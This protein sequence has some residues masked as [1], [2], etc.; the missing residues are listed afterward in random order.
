MKLQNIIHNLLSKFKKPNKQEE[1]LN[2]LYDALKSLRLDNGLYVASTGDF[3]KQ[4]VWLRDTFYAALPS[5]KHNPKEYQQ[6]YHTLL[7]YLKMIEEKYNKFS[8]MIE[9]PYPKYTYRYLHARIN[10]KTMDEVHETWQNKQGDVVGELLFGIALGEKNNIK[11]IR[12]KTDIHIIN[13]MIKYIEAL[14]YWK[15]MDSGIWEE[16]EGIRSSS[17]GAIVSGLKAIKELNRNDIVIPENLI[18]KGKIVLSQLLPNET[19]YR[20]VDMS[21]LTLIYPFNVVSEKQRDEILNNVETRLLRQ[22]GVIRYIGDYYFNSDYSNPVGNEA[23]WTMGLAYLSIIYFEMGN[24]EKAKYYLNKILDKCED[25]KVPELYFSKT[26]KPN[27][28]TILGWSNAL[29]IIALENIL[30]Y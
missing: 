30:N 13:L 3:Y 7:D 23:E 15:D 28:N 16:D 2:K 17:I 24:I 9:N 26:D 22:N 21:L 27:E 29:T 20:D 8:A 18:M 10:A 19:K 4:F 12:D 6:T 1:I 11:I 5:L 25:G 14:E